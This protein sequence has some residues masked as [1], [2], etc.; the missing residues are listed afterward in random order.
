MRTFTKGIGF[1][2]LTSLFLVGNSQAAIEHSLINDNNQNISTRSF[3]E[4]TELAELLWNEQSAKFIEQYENEKYRE[5]YKTAMRVYNLAEN[6]FGLN[7]V[8]T[9]DSLLKLGIITQIMGDMAKAEDYLYGALVILEDQLKPGNPDIA[10]ALT[11]LGNLYYDKKEFDKVEEFHKKALSIRLKA[12]GKEDSSVAQS[13][14]NLGVLYENTGEYDKAENH[15]REALSIWTQVYGPLHPYI[16]NT[17]A[18]LTNTY[19]AHKKLSNAILT[20]QRIVAFK[21]STLGI[22]HQ[23]VAQSLIDLGS[24]YVE[25]GQYDVAGG[26]Y[27][28]ALN[29]A[30]DF[31]KP[32]DPQLAMLMYTLANT[33]HMQ[34]RMEEPGDSFPNND[35]LSDTIAQDKNLQTTI[36]VQQALPLYVR[37]A[38]ILDA[39]QKTENQTALQAVLSE[40]AMLYKA[41]GEEDK[42]IETESRISMNH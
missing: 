7:D 3:H 37:A 40:L 19:I 2:I 34:A 42:A 17:L 25:Q 32:T 16:G 35:V 31:L 12:F 24:L 41:I 20:Q 28:E 30:K 39:K 6:N 5:A 15:Y 26:T 38:E 1:F 29:I 23:E 9:A 4:T 11:N 27:K 18:N 36:L 10:I 33:Y 22:D 21:K 14:Y 8:N 13:N